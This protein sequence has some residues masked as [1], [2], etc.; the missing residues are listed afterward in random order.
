MVVFIYAAQK[1]LRGTH[2][3]QWDTLLP[4]KST[5][6]ADPL[7]TVRSRFGP[8][9]YRRNMWNTG[10]TLLLRYYATTQKNISSRLETQSPPPPLPLLRTPWALGTFVYPPF[11]TEFLINATCAASW[12]DPP[13]LTVGR[14]VSA[15]VVLTGS[16]RDK[17]PEDPAYSAARR[18]SLRP[19]L[20]LSLPLRSS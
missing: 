11:E 8:L 4:H 18:N 3:I 1:C 12:V 2:I 19:S 14:N 16:I 10:Y 20:F 5:L 13:I 7:S 9:L 6:R 17:F 15:R